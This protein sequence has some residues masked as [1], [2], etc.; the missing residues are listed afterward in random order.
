MQRQWKSDGLRAVGLSNVI[1]F[2]KIQCLQ[3]LNDLASTVPNIAWAKGLL[4]DLS[5]ATAS[6]VTIGQRFQA[7][8][9]EETLGRRVPQSKFTPWTGSFVPVA[10]SESKGILYSLLSSPVPS[11]SP[12]AFPLSLFFISSFCL[13]LTFLGFLALIGPSAL[14]SF[15][16]T[17]TH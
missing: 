14:L 11:S 5:R 10:E 12:P 3:P 13:S 17:T 4:R 9:P 1:S 6:K 2:Q 16:C 8:N 15:H 7:S